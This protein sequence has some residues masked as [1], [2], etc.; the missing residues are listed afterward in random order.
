MGEMNEG[1][2]PKNGARAVKEWVIFWATIFAVPAVTYLFWWNMQQEIKQTEQAAQCFTQK[3]AIGIYQEL[4]KKIDR[5]DVP[6]PEVEIQLDH[7][8][9][10]LER[11]QREVEWLR[12]NCSMRNP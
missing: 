4:G 8:S 2:R 6:P 9:K 3:Q 1:A 12:Q 5:E 10:E 11:L 7:L